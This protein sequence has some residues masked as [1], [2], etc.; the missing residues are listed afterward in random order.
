[1]RGKQSF[2]L[3]ELLIVI[4]I[5]A[6][7]ALIAMP[8]YLEAQ[9]RAKVARCRADMKSVACAMECYCVDYQ[10]YP[11]KP[12]MSA[13]RVWQVALTTPVTYITAPLPD[14]FYT[15]ESLDNRYYQYSHC[16]LMRSWIFVSVGPDRVDDFD[17]TMWMCGRWG[18]YPALYDPTNGAISYGDV[19]RLSKQGGHVP[20]YMRGD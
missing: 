18:T 15:G 14:V 19:Y 9:T 8:N 20:M 5:V 3:I 11:P 1:M 7:L 13:R 12:T 10:I 2:T 6:I 4:A 16:P 17:E